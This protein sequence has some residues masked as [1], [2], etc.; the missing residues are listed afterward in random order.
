M[1]TFNELRRKQ[2]SLSGNEPVIRLALIGDTA[3]QLLATAICG[4]GADRGFRIDLFEA[5]YNQVEQ[6]LLNPASELY[7][8]N[9]DYIVIFQSTHKL[10]EQHSLLTA[11]KSRIS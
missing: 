3:T 10:A 2:K 9:G 8:F 11:K 7:Q 1:L 5:D 6:Q 4:M